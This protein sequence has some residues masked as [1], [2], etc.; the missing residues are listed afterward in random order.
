MIVIGMFLFIIVMLITLIIV[1]NPAIRLSIGFVSLLIVVAGTIMISMNLSSHL[2]MK[3]VSVTKTDEIYTAGQTTSPNNIL[4]TKQLG[5]KADNYVFVYR[6][7]LTA[8]KATTHFVP[9]TKTKD[10]SE[11]AKKT[12]R[13]TRTNNSKAEV[14]T[15]TTRWVWKSDFYESMFKFVS[16]NDILVRTRTM[17]YVPHNW[18]VLT[19]E[20]A[21]QMAKQQAAL[22]A[23]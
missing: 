23:K 11:T 13:W 2:G 5:T 16:K 9:S 22:A 4:I 21:A 14:S 8:K 20:Q 10:I 19:A 17:V 15:T 18:T 6:Q 12:A 3:Q 1:K 7:S